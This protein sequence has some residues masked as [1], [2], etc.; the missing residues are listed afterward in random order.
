MKTKDPTDWTFKLPGIM[1]LDNDP[2]T[3]TVD[4]L[5]AAG[6]LMLKD[7]VIYCENIGTNTPFKAGMYIIKITLNDKKNSVSYNLSV[8]VA[9][10]TLDSFK[11]A[12]AIKPRD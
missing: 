12:S 1:D 3:L 4:F 5:S 9:D 2:V 6:F 11:I 8:F 10:L 7:N